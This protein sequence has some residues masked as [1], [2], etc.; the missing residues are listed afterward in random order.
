MIAEQLAEYSIREG[1]G[2]AWVGLGWFAD[3]DV[4]QLAVLGH[5]F[6][7]GTCGIATFL[8]AHARITRNQGSADLASAAIAHLRNELRGRRGPHLGRV[9]GIGGATGLGSILYGLTCISRL[10]D[11]DGLM[12]DAIGVARLFTDDLIAADNQLDVVGGSAGAILGL[13]RLYRDTGADEVL[14]R[15]V[16]CGTHLLRRQRRGPHGRRSW[17][18]R[19]SNNQA[20]N[21]MS[22]GAS[23]F[24]YALAALA[25]ASG[26]ENLAEAA[27]ECLDFERLNFDAQ[28][29]DWRDFRVKEPHWRSQWCHGAVGIGLARLGITKLGSLERDA[30]AADIEAALTGA[31]RGWPAHADTLCCGALGSVELVREAGKTLGREDLRRLASQRLSAVLHTKAAAGSYRWNTPVSSR[32]NVG[33]FRGLAGVGY[34]CLREADGSLPNLLIW[35]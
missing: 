18:C 7:N 3:S 35:E 23:G 25:A 34:T 26:R 14:Q 6:Y 8:A 11:D 19:T 30:V 29:S 20:L 22:H 21:G 16:A 15:A 4:S 24:A 17:P 9:M 28:R 13:L 33:L 12:R 32:L 2:A 31:A 27:A 10:L 1:S 5:D